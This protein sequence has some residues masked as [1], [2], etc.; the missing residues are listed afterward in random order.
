M[1][2]I[3]FHK[4]AAL[5]VLA[6]FAGWVATGH[7][8]S[9]GSA[10]DTAEKKADEAAAPAV[11]RTV[12][13]ITPQHVTHARAI[14]ISGHTEAD[15]RAVLAARVS[16]VIA[17]LPFKQG[18]TV[19]QGDRVLMLDAEE[20]TAAVE[21]ARALLKQREAEWEAAERLGKAGQLPKLQVDNAFS[22]LAS[23][24]SL[25]QAAEAE[26]A[27]NE[28]KAPFN[29]IIDKIPVEIGNSVMQ[30]T[31][32]ATVL[33]LDP[34]VAKGE[35]SERDLRY[36]NIGDEAKARLVNGETVT[37]HLRY[38]SRDASAQTRTFPI[39]IAIP[40]PDRAIPA[41]MTAEITLLAE[42]TDSIVLPRSVVTLSGQGD[43]GVRGVDAA[44]KVVFFPIDIVDDTPKGIVLA[45]IPA[46]AKIIIAGQ[47]LVTEGDEVTAVEADADTVRQLMGEGG[48]GT[49]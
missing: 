1:A 40:N 49:Q 32:V 43:L 39:E 25:L 31:E 8:S 10:Q 23:A 15:K 22:A 12:S 36:L 35:V 11:R 44:N 16:G 45:G 18:D 5:A 33:A 48:N 38:V 4:L 46:A 34:V 3:R 42:P 47:D 30:G 17:E 6:G 26:L 29:G 7:F 2:R 41:G 24:R 13:V 28:V 20:K 14:R 27:R 37:G 21:N 9:V 19:A